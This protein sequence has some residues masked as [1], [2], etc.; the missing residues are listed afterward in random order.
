[1]GGRRYA[2]PDNW[3]AHAQGQDP[4][5]P[6][7][8][9]RSLLRGL[10]VLLTLSPGYREQYD[11][12]KGSTRREYRLMPLTSPKPSKLIKIPRLRRDDADDNGHDDTPGSSPA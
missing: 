5:V 6:G 11:R 2:A 7:P 10:C 9:G 3:T 1:M 8:P 12:P 4:E